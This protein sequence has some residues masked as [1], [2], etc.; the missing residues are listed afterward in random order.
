VSHTCAVLYRGTIDTRS[1][2][3]R[4]ESSPATRETLA[5]L[6]LFDSPF[7]L[8]P[9][10]LFMYLSGPDLEPRNAGAVNPV[11]RHPRPS[12][13]PGTHT[14]TSNRAPFVQPDERDLKTV[15]QGVGVRHPRRPH[16]R[17]PHPIP[18]QISLLLQLLRG[19][20]E[21]STR[22]VRLTDRSNRRFLC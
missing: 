17:P 4:L 9:L 13:R 3:H 18:P 12:P 10:F 8:Q 7:R 16:P 21:V 11:R 19:R 14:R 6:F 22:R 15:S 2:S 20:G 5:N 1:R